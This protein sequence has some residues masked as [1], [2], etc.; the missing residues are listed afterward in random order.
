[1][2]QK[3]CNEQKKEK[4][5]NWF[6]SNY[7][8]PSECCPWDN[9]EGYYMH[10][11]REK[12]EDTD[13]ILRNQF[14]HYPDKVVKE[15]IDELNKESDKWYPKDDFDL[16]EDYKYIP[17][18][19]KQ[20]FDKH[21][22]QIQELLKQ[23]IDNKLENTFF[24]MIFVSI[25]TGMEVYLKDTFTNNIF[26][27]DE[28]IENFLEKSININKN[29]YTLKEINGYTDFVQEKTKEYLHNIIWH[30]LQL[31][32]NLYNE[33]FDVRIPLNKELFDAVTKRHIIV[34][35]NGL[36]ENNKELTMSKEVIENLIKKVSDFVNNIESDFINNIENLI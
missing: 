8:K 10:G 15:L 14:D 29:K 33:A 30:K 16:D 4:M 1:M 12:L 20:I 25:I 5:R 3:K 13:Y 22:D 24:K 35:R 18:D 11:W 28:F 17:E 6:F 21:I 19:P 36:D 23:N 31:V 2:D 9:E 27:N 26:G 34:H 32:Y 7:E